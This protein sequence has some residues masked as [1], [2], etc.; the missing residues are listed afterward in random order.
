MLWYLIHAR[1]FIDPLWSNTYVYL[2]LMLYCIPDDLVDWYF[3]FFAHIL[4]LGDAIPS[5]LY[6][7]LFLRGSMWG[8]S[9]PRSNLICGF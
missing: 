6:S 2:Y 9:H 7:D 5:K 4:F 8:K 3:L 1:I